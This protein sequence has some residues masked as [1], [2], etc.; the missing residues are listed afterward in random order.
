MLPP[1]VSVTRGP[2]ITSSVALSPDGRTLVVAGTSKEGQRLYRRP[3]EQLEA[4]PLAGTERGSSPFFSW[5][6]ASVGF[7]ADGKLKRVPAG[8]GSPGFVA[9]ASWGPDNRIVFGDGASARL[10][11]VDADNGKVGLLSEVESGRLPE[12]LPDGKTV[13]FESNGCS[14]V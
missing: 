1:G 5:D 6:G 13:L 12:I 11:I 14:C 9:G 7:F 4:T 3:L 8:G 10:H 2:G